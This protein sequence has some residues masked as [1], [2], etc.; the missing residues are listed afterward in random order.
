MLKIRHFAPDDIPQLVS[1]FQDMQRHY[2]MPVPVADDIRASLDALP[3]GAGILLAETDAIVG[4]VAF[5]S[6]YPG[7]GLK[8]GLFM[9]ELFVLERARGQ[10]VGKALVRAL[11]RL[12]IER[13]FARID[14]T[15]DRRNERLVCFYTELGAL[16]QEEKVFFRLTADALVEV[17][18]A[19]DAAKRPGPN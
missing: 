8:P 7:P 13:G 2:G 4:F 3:A 11:A 15:A 12:A 18:G 5:S 19:T 9:K 1:L 17:A 16:A 14:W 6:L 10:G